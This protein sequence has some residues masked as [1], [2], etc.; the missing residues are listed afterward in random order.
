[1][2]SLPGSKADLLRRCREFD[3]H[4][5]SFR[6]WSDT[7]LDRACFF[8]FGAGRELASALYFA[9]H[10]VGRQVLVD[11]HE[12]A[13]PELIA[14]VLAQLGELAD[15]LD[16][17]RRR[18]PS[19]S[20]SDPL[21]ELHIDYR[22]PADARATGLPDASVDCI[23]STNT[24]EHI[25]PEDIRA[26]LGECHRIL[27]ADGVLSMQI[28]YAD[29]YAAFDRRIDAYHFLRYSDACWRLCNPSSH[30]QN[31]LRHGWFRAELRAAGFVV[32]DEELQRAPQR[33][34]LR[35]APRFRSL[36]LDQLLISGSRMA[37]RKEAA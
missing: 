29:H 32:L 35:R 25:P 2:R 5:H 3:W 11:L 22:A 21:A 19:A 26:I 6:K 18:L 12:L 36:P 10:G 27:R 28:D 23:H 13:R 33:G 20:A 14:H 24:L 37:C 9:V 15:E 17:D 16:I 7:A 4:L 30:Y 31:R 8:E 34:V 1:M